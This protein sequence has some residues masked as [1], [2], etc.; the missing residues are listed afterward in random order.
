MTSYYD[1][2]KA[3]EQVA[4]QGKPQEVA[5]FVT[6]IVE[7]WRQ[8][9]HTPHAEAAKNQV[10]DFLMNGIRRVEWTPI[11][12][13]LRGE[14]KGLGEANELTTTAYSL[15]KATDWQSVVAGRSI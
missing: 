13:T 14:R 4:D 8:H 1:T 9:Q 12:D 6:D 11:Y 15:L 5:Q 2:Y 3:I 10:Q 7:R